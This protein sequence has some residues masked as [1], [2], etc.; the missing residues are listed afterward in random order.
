MT[1]K[2]YK[3]FACSDIHGAYTPWMNALGEAGFDPNNDNHKIIVCGDLF[4]RM[5]ETQKVYDFTKE[6]IDKNKL[7]YIKGNH[8][9][10][11]L[12]CV[13]R[14]YP[15]SFDWSNG[16]AKTI[17]DLAPNAKTFDMACIVAYNK[18]QDL[19]QHM[20]NYVESEHFVFCHGFI[21][22]NCEDSLPP[23]YE[24]NRKY[25]KMENWREAHQYQ[26]DDA[27]WLCSYDMIDQ[28]LGIDK[29]IVAGHWHASYGRYKRFGKPE[30]SPYT[31]FSPFYYDNK[32][33]M[34]DA[35]TAYSGKVNC[36]VLEDEFL[37]GKNT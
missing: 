31:D 28:G 6:M 29:C 26:W 2:K 22:V 25:S 12:D 21:P 13:E 35:A 10:L 30:L 33:I 16:T 34:I 24:K 4:D 18:I 17:I 1:I 14:G 20:V 36:L 15:Q 3:F 8:E 23:W 32:L 11:L 27:A 19:F 7:I 37:N 9:Q 5:P